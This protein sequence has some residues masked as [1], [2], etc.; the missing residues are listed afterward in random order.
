MAIV[1]SLASLPLLAALACWLPDAAL[2]QQVDPPA[3]PADQEYAA[4]PMAT[5][6]GPSAGTPGKVSAEM[7]ARMPGAATPPRGEQ[8]AP[9][10]EG[11][12]ASDAE[13][14]AGS[15]A[16]EPDSIP[17][18]AEPPAALAP[19]SEES[20]VPTPLEPIVVTGTR[21]EHR[22]SD[23]P[24]EV[25]LIDA[26]TIHHSGARDVAEL[27]EREGGLHVTRQAG[28]GTSIEIQGLSSEH[29]LILIDGRRLNGRVFG[30]IDLTRI[31]IDRIERIEV[32]KGPSSAL[33]G[34]DA[35]GGVVNIITRRGG[36]EL[37]G[38]L[39]L[40]ADSE[41]N[42]ETFARGGWTLGTL[43]GESGAG[44]DRLRAYDLDEATPSEDGA[45]SE[46]GYAST[47]ARWTLSDRASIGFSG[48]YALNDARRVDGGL[49]GRIYDTHKRI[50][51]LRLGVSPEIEL[52]KRTTLALDAYYNRYFDQ[53]V[54]LPR[55]PAD[56]TIDEETLDELYAA[57]GQVEHRYDIHRMVFGAEAQ[58][59]ALEADRL[60]S[61]GERDRQ[62]VYAQDEIGLLDDALLIVPGL[63][64]DRDS[65]F[66][67]QFSPKLAARY[68][69]RDDLIL[70]AGYGR[71]YRVPDFKQL[72]LR[73]EN[74]G[75]GYRVDGNPE[76][77][78]ETSTGFNLGATW[79]PSDTSSFT[80]GAYH[81][82]VDD[83]I[84]IVQ[85]ESG[86][87]ILFSYRN[88][89]SATLTG[90]DAQARF[91]P[92]RPLEVQFGYGWLDS[93]DEDTGRSLSG[94]ADHRANAALR[95]EQSD[96]AL[97]LRGVWV[98]ERR[99]DTEVDAGGPPT[100]AGEADA[101][102]LFDFRA[103]WTRWPRWM[104]AAGIE[105]L[106]DEGDPAHLPIA[107]RSVYL[108]LQWNP[109]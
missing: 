7:D 26:N 8:P 58:I 18:A 45:K 60:D 108:E 78:P 31:H 98:G 81:N 80:I 42:A 104:L 44:Y 93:E 86:P 57:G 105:N 25:Q 20:L 38:T 107:P 43:H 109:Y 53:Y 69:L 3:T 66:G 94:R 79:L 36:S 14:G 64:Y 23:S 39:G 54:Q 33:Y 32:V 34:A 12:A 102:T 68:Q 72:L 76:L 84:E 90:L 15:G 100:Q 51:D 30:A 55:D 82:R 46:N 9:A 92:W 103:E 62:S 88:V 24:V 89:A 29:V 1:K 91:R 99:F 77:Q 11:K 10:A 101:Y 4:M 96:Y 63:R 2:A 40:R 19:L 97:N 35:L 27:L 22:L 28:R 70:R 73:F 17:L 16:D 21:T 67:D 75:V 59:E 47:D 85:I 71:G 61:S 37:G 56:A 95:Y 83:L 87:P 5:D 48:A 13:S 50:E 6:F 41:G 65:Q 52:G 106:L 49:A 74:P